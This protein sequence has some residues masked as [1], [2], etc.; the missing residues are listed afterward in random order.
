ME[1]EGGRGGFLIIY[2]LV[3]CTNTLEIFYVF[4]KLREV[5]KLTLSSSSGCMDFFFFFYG[6]L[7]NSFHWE[8]N[9][10]NCF[11][12]FGYRDF[13]IFLLYSHQNLNSKERLLPQDLSLISK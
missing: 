6:L 8:E 4:R 5:L 3:F 9:L 7:S 10:R 2:F 1:G 12:F 11:D 13:C